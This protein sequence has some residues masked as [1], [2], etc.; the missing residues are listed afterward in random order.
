MIA[1]RNVTVHNKQGLHL[2]VAAAVAESACK[3][4]SD[5]QLIKEGTVV[6]AK[7]SI[8]ILTLVAE[9]GMELILRAVG[10]DARE[11]VARLEGMFQSGFDQG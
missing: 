3:F 5:I 7:S 4:Q 6:N 2:R 11:A 1:E 8:E 9:Q 10:P